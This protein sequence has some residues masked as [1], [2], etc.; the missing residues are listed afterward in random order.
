MTAERWSADQLGALAD[1]WVAE[2]EAFLSALH[3][4]LATQVSQNPPAP[5]PPLAAATYG[6]E[7]AAIGERLSSFLYTMDSTPWYT[8]QHRV[9]EH[10]HALEMQ[11]GAAAQI[12]AARLAALQP[13]PDASLRHEAVR[14][15]L[16]I[17]QHILHLYK[18]LGGQFDFATIRFANRLASQIKY[19]LYPVR[20]HLPALRRYWLLDTADPE[21]YE[22]PAA[23]VDPCSG[24]QRYEAE[25]SR[26]AY[27]CYVPECYQADRPW[28]VLLTLHGGS[29][30][31]E[32]FLWTWLK[33]AKSRGYLLV[34]A[35]SFGPTW[36]PWDAPSLMFILDEIQAR[37]HVDSDQILLTGL[38]DGGSFSYEVGFAWPER[39]HG[40]AVVAGILRPHQ[41]SAQASQLPVY[42]AHGAQDQ[43]FPVGYI[44]LVVDKLREW[45]HNVT[46][47]ELA[48]FG[49]AY[50][51]GENTAIL[52]W[53]E[54]LRGGT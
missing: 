37:Y 21:V 16:A 50:P 46:Y 53:F 44:R 11:Y 4:Y 49:H 36:F 45:G 14:Q 43:L 35:K 7:L 15:A 33:Y 42:I 47:R 1:E 39:F 5:L 41:R 27:T 19:R 3:T 38:S 9:A 18:E 20:Q 52:D 22:P 26:G 24:I 17:M 29:G 12:D 48:G 31:D 51:P 30:N 34:S 40:L 6:A 13:P 54:G 23:N 25:G 28:P 2:R 32:D 10:Q 8:F